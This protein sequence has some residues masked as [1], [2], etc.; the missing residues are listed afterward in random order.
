M[1]LEGMYGKLNKKTEKPMK[2]I[3]KSNERLIRLV[4]D[5][6]SVSRIEAGKMELELEKTSL[7]NII[8]EV[9]NELKIKAQKK[10]L[11]LTFEKP[12]DILPKILIDRAKIRQAIL[13]IIDNAIKYTNKGG[14]TIKIKN[15]KTKIKII[16]TDTGE[17]MT[18]KELS[19]MFKSFSRGAAGTRL[20]I[21]GIG[22]GLYIAKCFIEMHQGKIW[23]QSRGR[24]KGSTFYIELLTR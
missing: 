1:I 11:Y 22:L 14:I 9:I 3:Y 8:P 10:K 17:G 12:K 6:L 15:Q 16:I 18:K 13:N 2:N 4:N 7:E 24:G 20:F 5:F 21:E 19:K 23:A